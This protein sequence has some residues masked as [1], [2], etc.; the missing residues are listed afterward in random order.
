M[1]LRRLLTFALA[2]ACSC[3][4]GCGD[5]VDA[6]KQA[7]ISPDPSVCVAEALA[8]YPYFTRIE[9]SRHE[10]KDGKTIVEAACELDVAAACRE[11]NGAGLALARQGVARD[12]FLARFVVEGLPVQVRPLEAVHVTQCKNG[13]RL[14][15]ADPKY[16]NAIYNREAVRFFC[17]EGLNCPGQ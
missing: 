6:A 11:V 16:L 8:R 17:L 9:W 15:F 4:A 13:K 3:F 5:P 7:R 1:P 10:D 2:L 12:Y 14:T